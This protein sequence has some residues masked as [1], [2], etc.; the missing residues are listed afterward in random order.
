MI[1]NSL[2]FNNQHF[3]RVVYLLFCLY[4]STGTGQNGDKFKTATTKTATQGK[5]GKGEKTVTIILYFNYTPG[6]I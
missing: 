4:D 6:N 3:K 5:A 2:L 1:Y